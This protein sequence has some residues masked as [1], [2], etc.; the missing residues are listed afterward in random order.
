METEQKAKILVGVI[1]LMCLIGLTVY[2]KSLLNKANEIENEILLADNISKE[3]TS[4]LTVEE[5][6]TDEE[7]KIEEEILPTVVYD[8]L[9]MEELSEKLNRSLNSTISGYGNLIANRSIELGVDPYLAVAI[10]LHETGCSWDC[11][12]LVNQCYN[13][14]GQ[15]GA[16]GCWGGSYR[17]FN[18]LEE[19]INA[20]L[21]NLY[22]NYYA[23]GLTTP[24]TINTK[25]AESTTWYSKI[26]A[27]ID[28]IKV[29]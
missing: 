1:V 10:I 3:T 5:T 27:Y 9:T 18:S 12:E 16:P 20:F 23:V 8:N 6:K 17:A 22:Y 13:V 2:S 7:T 11:S 26:Y 19:G 4:L 24:E 21:E 25:Y 29:N 14:G 15:K 28:K